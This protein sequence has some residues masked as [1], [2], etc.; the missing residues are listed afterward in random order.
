METTRRWWARLA[1]PDATRWDRR[2]A[3]LGA[4]ATQLGRGLAEVAALAASAP[5]PA[6]PAV[7]RYSSRMALASRRSSCQSA[8]LSC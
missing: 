3:A 5:R 8:A 7:F 1:A 4:R 2:L 6:E